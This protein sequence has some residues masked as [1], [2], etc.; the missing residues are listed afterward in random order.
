MREN[1]FAEIVFTR[2]EVKRKNEFEGITAHGPVT[3]H[4]RQGDEEEGSSI[5]RLTDRGRS[6]SGK[7]NNQRKPSG[8]VILRYFPSR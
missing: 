5:R 4:G 2:Q 6:R 8:A 3:S 7:S 1:G